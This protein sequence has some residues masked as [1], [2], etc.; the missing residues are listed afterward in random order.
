[1]NTIDS[2]LERSSSMDNEVK[3]N[4]V[5]NEAMS[6]ADAQQHVLSVTKA[7]PVLMDFLYL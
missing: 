4:S 7:C 1:M 2:Y 6:Y 5:E 3:I